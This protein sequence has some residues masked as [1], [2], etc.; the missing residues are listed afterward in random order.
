MIKK[1][2]IIDKGLKMNKNNPVLT[3]QQFQDKILKLIQKH[4]VVSQH[5]ESLENYFILT[6]KSIPI[7]QITIFPHLNK[8]E[9]YLHSKQILSINTPTK[10]I[11]YTINNKSNHLPTE[12]MVHNI[13]SAI[14][15]K[16]SQLQI[17][18]TTKKQKIK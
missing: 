8:C 13:L 15:L 17:S 4:T 9:I 12:I 10:P 6:K 11:G 2:N 7:L 1:F 5:T 3:N 14:K 16:L 18:T